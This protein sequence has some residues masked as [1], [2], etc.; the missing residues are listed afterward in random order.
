MPIYHHNR[1]ASSSSSLTATNARHKVTGYTWLRTT[2]SALSTNPLSFKFH[3]HLERVDNSPINDILSRPHADELDDY[4]AYKLAI[5]DHRETERLRDDTALSLATR[6]TMGDG[7]VIG[8]TESSDVDLSGMPEALRG[9]GE[10]VNP[11]RL[12][13][14]VVDGRERRVDFGTR[15]GR[16]SSAMPNAPSLLG[17][18]APVMAEMV[19][20]DGADGERY[21]A[22]DIE[23]GSE[24]EFGE[25][26]DGFD[27]QNRFRV[28]DWRQGSS[29]C[30]P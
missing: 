2:Y 6:A 4:R 3:V 11:R 23:I 16:R 17:R 28:V 13:G 12:E 14:A 7:R 10:L 19:Y 21:E 24:D 1:L 22:V 9:M 20:H 8:V 15:A 18:T 25:W 27:S 30:N 26:A 5:R 29:P